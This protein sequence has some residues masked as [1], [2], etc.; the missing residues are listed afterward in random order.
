M[1]SPPKKLNLE[2]AEHEALQAAIQ[3]Q[4]GKQSNTE[5]ATASKLSPKKAAA[6]SGKGA[7]KLDK[8]AAGKATSSSEAAKAASP[9]K[10]GKAAPC[11]PAANAPINIHS[12]GDE[13]NPVMIDDSGLQRTIVIDDSPPA[14]KSHS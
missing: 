12:D 11:S 13:A 5:Q 6:K 8:G 3:E 14:I 7:S 1:S 4:E 2:A 9:S 10:K